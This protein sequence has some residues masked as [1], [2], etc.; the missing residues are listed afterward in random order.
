MNK[1]KLLLGL[2]ACFLLLGALPSTAAADEAFTPLVGYLET[3]EHPAYIS[4]SD[5]LV[6]P[7]SNLTRAEAAS[8]I[9][10]LLRVKPE[11]VAP[12]FADV[13]QGAWYQPQVDALAQLGVVVGM[14]ESLGGPLYAP[15]ANITRAEFAVLLSR[16]FP[17]ETGETAFTDLD[18]N[19]WYYP[20]M[21]NAVQKGWIS[22]YRDGTARPNANITRAEAAAMLNKMLGRAADAAELDKDSKTLRFLD[23]PADHWAYYHIMEASTPHTHAADETGAEIWEEFTIP[24]AKY[25][26]GYRLY[27]GSLYKID[28]AGHYVRNV[29]D[30]VLQFGGDGAYTTGNA[31]LDGYLRNAVR[32]NTVDGD[33]LQNNWNRLYQ[34]AA[35]KN[36]SYLNR[37]YL[38]D[39]QTGWEID[40]AIQMFETRKGNCYNYAAVT[41]FLARSVGFQAT[42]MAGFAYMAPNGYFVNHG[43]TQITI[44]GEKLVADPEL[45]YV[46]AV[47]N[48]IYTWDLNLK[49]YSEVEPIYRWKGVVLK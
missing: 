31:K 9:Y 44:D 28:E 32:A 30:G 26:P 45:Q 10:S 27:R 15:E 38:K 25:A 34:Y 3:S 6:R 8:L 16:F 7:D 47:N 13:A 21:N 40:R 1:L 24:A 22:G 2:F 37:A 46:F 48:D 12:H 43:W 11:G 36:F 41:T 4:G 5:D 33:S 39:G 19:A 17:M 20:Y 35:G 49:R 14:G 29:T 18:P 42:P 23:L